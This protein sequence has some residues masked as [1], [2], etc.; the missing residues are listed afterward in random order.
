MSR[1]NKEK[2]PNVMAT[3]PFILDPLWITKGSFI[4]SEYFNYVLLDASMKY[5]KELDEGNIDHF[6]EVLFHS[7][8]LNNLAMNGRLFT[9]KY[10]T[11]LSNPRIKEIQND[12]KSLYAIKKETTEVLRNANFVFLNILLDYMTVELEI[13]DK[14]KLFYVNQKIHLYKDIFIV[15][16]MM[17]EKIYK[18]WKLSEDGRKV[19]GHSFDKII[20]IEVDEI[21]ENVLPEAIAELNDP[22]FKYLDS[23]QNLCF[24]IIQ[25]ETDEE[26]AAKTV[27]DTV[28]LNKGIAKNLNFE[29]NIIGELYRL[30]WGEKVMPF[31]LA[32]WVQNEA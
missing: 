1:I 11:I 28:L 3:P 2:T 29:T 22:R 4:D 23:K 21:R 31:N 9:N 18:I 6:N 17:G 15:T 25:E 24:A 10:K 32:Q 30:L 5:R 26:L 20:D 16:N 27:K 13:F 19:L 14:I 8:N 7:L 12:L